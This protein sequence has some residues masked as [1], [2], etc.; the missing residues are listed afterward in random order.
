MSKVVLDTNVFVSGIFFRPSRP[1]RIVD[2]WWDRK[3]DLVVSPYLFDETLKILI[4]TNKRLGGGLSF[5][6]RF[7]TT[8]KDFAF[9]V[10]VEPKAKICRDPKDNVVLDT[11]CQGEA[12]WIV[13]GDKDLL[14]LKKYKGVAIVT[15]AQF[16]KELGL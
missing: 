16:V 9:W 3:I 6:E 14:V 2:A 11:A 5:I 7:K 15:P 4:Q 13:T 1:G 10:K 12:K 8:I